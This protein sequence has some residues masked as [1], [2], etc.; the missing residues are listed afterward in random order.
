VLLPEGLVEEEVFRQELVDWEV[1]RAGVLV[2]FDKLV[3][4]ETEVLK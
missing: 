3:E 1:V 4:L 2:V